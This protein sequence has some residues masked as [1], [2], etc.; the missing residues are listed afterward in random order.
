MCF[1]VH[2]ECNKLK[3]DDFEATI[4]Q[5]VKSTVY[6]F[7]EQ[8]IINVFTYGISGQFFGASA[9]IETIFDACLFC[10]QLYLAHSSH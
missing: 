2:E 1:L 4:Q 9:F 8:E 6:N 3:C 10:S 7:C 5:I